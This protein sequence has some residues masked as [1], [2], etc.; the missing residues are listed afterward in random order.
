MTYAWEHISGDNSMTI[1]SPASATTTFTAFVSAGQTKK[2]VF[3]WT[4]TDTG[5]GLF[6][7]GL[8]SVTL[9]EGL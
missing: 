8:V 9:T 7:Q 5:S 6:R 2:A 4:A 3:N 1:N